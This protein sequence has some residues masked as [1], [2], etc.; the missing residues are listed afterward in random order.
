MFNLVILLKLKLLNTKYFHGNQLAIKFMP[1][2]LPPK[3][4]A[5]VTYRAFKDEYGKKNHY[6]SKTIHWDVFKIWSF[7]GSNVH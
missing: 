4:D 7:L 3:Y 5:Y 6:S 2:L 1:I